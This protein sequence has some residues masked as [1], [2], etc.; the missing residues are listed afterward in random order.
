MIN[1]LL[2]TWNPV[3]E[4]GIPLLDEQHRG[5]VSIIN[6]FDYSIRSSKELE[7]NLNAIFMIVDCYSRLHFTAEE[8]FMRSAGYHDLENH[9]NEHSRFTNQSFAFVSQS[10]R[11]RDPNIY[12]DFLLNWW[13][14]HMNNSDKKYVPFVKAHLNI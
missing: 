3:S 11:L 1:K 2:I 5:I 9:I 13:K 8:D 7:F 10:M 12:L 4:I 6:S 14:M